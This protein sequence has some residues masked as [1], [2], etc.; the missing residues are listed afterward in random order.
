MHLSTRRPG[1]RVAA[2]VL[3]AGLSLSACGGSGSSGGGDSAK[4]DVAGAKAAI[5]PYIGKTTAFPVD[6]PL[7]GRLPAGTKIAYVQ[8]AS[9]ICGIFATIFPPATKILGASFSVT[10]AGPSADQQQSAFTS[11]LQNKPDGILLPAIEPDAISNELATAKQT[12][13]PVST[14]G[15]MDG[16]K[17][18]IGAQMLGRPN[19]ELAGKLLADWVVARKAGAAKPVF[20]TTPELSF[21]E[22]L[23]AGFEAEMK[24]RC[25][26]CEV[27]FE[28][29]PIASIGSSA[30]NLV[31]SDLQAHPDSNVAVFST[32][33]ASTGLPAAMK[34]AGL[35]IDTVGFAPNPANLQDIKNGDVTAGLG[36]DLPVMAWTQVDALARLILK[37][38][39]TEGEKK[40]IGPMQFLTAKDLTFDISKGWTG[41]PDFA[42]RFAKLWTTN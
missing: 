4:A 30:P 12:G 24:T 21:G 18:G 2:A 29:L 16:E 19:A 10:K 9:P 42:Q 41:Y 7:P 17:Y 36:V 37:A 5:A 1:G 28:K 22:P 3:I 33:E 35:K 14:N 25:A 8:C 26:A 39:L 13:I 38:P 40:Q 23:R 15:V 6:K 32:Q 34:T 27:R 20:Y 11:A 31:V